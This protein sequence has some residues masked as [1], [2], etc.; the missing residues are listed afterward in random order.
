LQEILS[1]LV[2]D[3]IEV[4]FPEN[5]DFP[6]KNK[7]YLIKRAISGFFSVEKPHFPVPEEKK[8]LRF[9]QQALY[10]SKKCRI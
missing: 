7:H 9:C 3:N 10:C 4:F 8:G 2:A 1:L 5:L 6:E